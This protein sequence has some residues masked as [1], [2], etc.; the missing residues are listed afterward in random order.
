MAIT[1]IGSAAEVD[2][3]ASLVTALNTATA[4]SLQK[5][6]N[7]SD[8]ASA[9]TARTNLGLGTAATMSSAQLAADTAFT[10]AYA[11]A[12]R[13]E[14]R[15]E[16]YGT[17]DPTGAADNGSIWAAAL[18]A[19]LSQTVPVRVSAPAGTYKVR[20]L[21]L[22]AN[23]LL[24][25]TNVT[26]QYGGSFGTVAPLE[27]IPSILYAEGSSGTP[28]PG[29]II[30]GGTII[31]DRPSTMWND[32][33]T[34]AQ[35]AIQ[36]NYCPGALVEN[37]T[38]H[39]VRQDAICFANSAGVVARY[40]T[41]YDCNDGAVEF[42]VGCSSGQVYGN[43]FTRVRNGVQSKPN[44]D[45]I[46][47]Q[48]NTMATFNE[49]IVA[50]GTRWRIADNVIDAYTT[51][52]GM[53]GTTY[54]AIA[55][56][57]IGGGT[58]VP[59][60]MDVLNIHNNIITGRTASAALN[61]FSDASWLVKNIT[62]TANTVRTC[63]NGATLSTGSTDAVISNNHLDCSQAAVTCSN[64]ANTCKL[65]VQGNRIAVSTGYAA[66]V[67]CAGAEFIGNRVTGSGGIKLESNST[68][69]TVSGNYIS[70][71]VGSNECVYLAATGA[72]VT[73]NRIVGG[74][75]GVRCNATDCVI[76]GNRIS[77]AQFWA[78]TI[79]AAV[80]DTVIVGNNLKGNTS[81]AVSDSGTTT[82][83]ANNRKATGA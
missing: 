50:H 16:D 59:T 33:V 13:K 51:S 25:L 22:Y 75:Q 24:D 29:I 76:T 63:K 30:R 38:I 3:V 48:G 23:T 41:V 70:I 40:N 49:G 54:P 83:E 56:Q 73:G 53:D 17:L 67:Y 31:G 39:D 11:R 26:L 4:S 14:I 42:R 80:V 6:S 2:P 46:L 19:A 21:R 28:L 72:M 78:V 45:D 44:Q 8:L 71:T 18:A 15:V 81:G 57:N 66:D 12:L 65:I 69:S 10:G 20:N 82:L 60:D 62:F 79:P 7:L 9:S 52:D 37:V 34:N 68:D 47:V 55:V 43:I 36:L 5:S 35:D 27:T 1:G 58:F 77:G 74:T 61:V 32:N 64:T